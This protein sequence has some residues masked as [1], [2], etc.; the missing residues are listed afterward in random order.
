MS[1]CDL[2]RSMAFNTY[3]GNNYEEISVADEPLLKWPLAIRL[4]VRLQMILEASIFL[5]ITPGA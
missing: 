2:L 5:K 1:N 4:V 3:G